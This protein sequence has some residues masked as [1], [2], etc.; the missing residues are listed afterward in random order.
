M[1]EPFVTIDLHGMKQDQAF[2]VIDRALFTNG[3]RLSN[4]LDT[5]VSQ[6]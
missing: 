1:S 5:R 3:W 6:R 4:P 2:R